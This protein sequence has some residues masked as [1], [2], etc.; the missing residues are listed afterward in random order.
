[1][2]I[3]NI[4]DEQEVAMKWLSVFGRY[5]PYEIMQDHVLGGSTLANHMWHI[6]TWGEVPCLTGDAARKAV[7]ELQY[8]SALGFFGGWSCGYGYKLENMRI[9]GKASSAVIDSK[10]GDCY[11][12]GK[13][14]EWTYVKTHESDL[15]PYF[16]LRSSIKDN[17][18]KNV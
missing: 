11:I 6:F 13:N 9:I 18:D 5:V 10:R 8:K 12:I 16:C 1:M 3:P 2:R 15:G 17:G 14:F 4:R 7:D